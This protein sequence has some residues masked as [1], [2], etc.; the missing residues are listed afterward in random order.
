MTKMK[1]TNVMNM[2]NKEAVLV[3]C[4]I[5]NDTWFNNSNDVEL[6]EERNSYDE[7]LDIF[8]P[9]KK[10][11]KQKL[12]IECL[13]ENLSREYSKFK[14]ELVEQR[15]ENPME[16]WKSCSHSLLGIIAKGVYVLQ[17]SSSESERHNSIAGNLMTAMKNRMSP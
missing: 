12:S 13:I 5:D 17:A 6:F 9:P 16:Y 14:S 10:L 2:I 11:Q 7:Y 3:E 1:F 8:E 15:F 4:E